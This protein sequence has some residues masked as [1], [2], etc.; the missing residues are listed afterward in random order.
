MKQL[1]NGIKAAVRRVMR[2]VAKLLNAITG[3]RITP[4]SVTWF[5]FIMHI[6]IAGLIATGH[7]VWAGVLLI[8][9]GLFDT[10]DGELARLQGSVS[11]AG[12]FLDASTDRFKEVLLYSAA[13]YLFAAGSHPKYAAIAVA[14]CGASICVSFLKAKGEAVVASLGK[15]IPYPELNKMFSGGLFPFEIR[16]LVLVIGLFAN[17]LVWAVS[18]IALFSTITAFQRLFI[19]SRRLR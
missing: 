4:N 10:L 5:G 19:I 13:A 8:I 7:V 18:A 2:L 12:G 3:G 17:Q 16:M 6:P 9:F 1:V 15:T 14:A 11:N